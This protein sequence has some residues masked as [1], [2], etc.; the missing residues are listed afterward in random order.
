MM[1]NF[2]VKYIRKHVFKLRFLSCLSVLRMD[3]TVYVVPRRHLSRYSRNSESNVLEFQ[4]NLSKMLGLMCSLRTF[5]SFIGWFDIST[6]IFDDAT[7][8]TIPSTFLFLYYTKYTFILYYTK[9]MFIRE[10]CKILFMLHTSMWSH[11]AKDN[12]MQIITR[13]HYFEHFRTS[14]KPQ[15]NVPGSYL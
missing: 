13:E 1:V 7:Y 4:E 5:V 9:H 2:I 14:R 10:Y 12:I 3:I 15:G 8:N 11:P 6:H